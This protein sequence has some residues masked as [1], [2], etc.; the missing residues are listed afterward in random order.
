MLTAARPLPH[1]DDADTAASA[2]ALP[3][4]MPLVLD[5]DGTLIRGDMLHKSF[6]SAVLRNPLLLLPCV[7]WLLRGRAALKRELA[8]R[9]RID[10][11]RIDVHEDVRALALKERAAGRAVVLATAADALLAE[12]LAARLGFIDHTFASD[13]TCNLKGP[14][15][16]ELL[17]RLFP[18]GFIYAGDSR[19]DLSV[20]KHAHG[21]VLVKGEASV[22]EAARALGRPVL[23]LSGRL[24]LSTRLTG[25]GGA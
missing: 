20:W 12:P 23:Q 24:A 14:A 19:A 18:R 4:M 3:L 6:A 21:I 9:S 8:W 22:A 2:F 17:T 13:G 5:L 25:T 1:R 15:K 10:W 11:D 16:A 7:A